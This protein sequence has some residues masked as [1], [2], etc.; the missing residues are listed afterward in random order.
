MMDN[1]CFDKSINV[2]QSNSISVLRPSDQTGSETY[3]HVVGLH[4][5]F[6]T[7]LGDATPHNNTEREGEG[8][9]DSEN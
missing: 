3:S 4:H 7:V 2:L 8:G 6:I 5:V 9:G 1:D